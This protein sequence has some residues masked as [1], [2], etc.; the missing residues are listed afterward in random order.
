MNGIR[1]RMSGMSRLGFIG[2]I[3]VVAAIAVVAYF[4]IDRGPSEPQ[5]AGGPATVR[6]MSG[7]QYRNSISAIFGEDISTS[8]RFAPMRRTEGL[9]NLGSSTALVTPSTLMTFET[10]A[11]SV[12]AQVMDE[13]HRDILIPCSPYDPTK[14]DEAC[15][16]E[17][18]SAT[19]RLLY[20]QPIGEVELATY[21]DG[22]RVG[23]E[24]FSDFYKG[25]EN[26]LMGMLLAPQFVY[27]IEHSEPDPDN[28]G[29]LRLDAYSKAQRLS[30]LLW[31]APPDD[32][33]LLAAESGAIH[34]DKGLLEQVDRMLESPRLE[35]GT[36]AF[37]DDMLYMAKYD[38]MA[39]DPLLFPAAT[40]SVVTA[41][42]EQTMRMILDHL[43]DQNADYR[44]LFTT[45]RIFLTQ[46]LGPI[47]RM[48]VSVPGLHDWIAYELPED[49][50]RPGLL[51]QVGFLSVYAHP[52]RS[53]AT[54]RGKGLRE[55]FM[56][57]KVPDPP[58]NVDFSALTDPS[59][60]LTTT[61][62]RL[63]FH[64]KVPACAGCHK[65]TDPIG[66]SLENFDGAAQYRTAQNGEEIDASGT[67]SG[68][69]YNNAAGLAAAV[70]D[71]PAITSCLV[72]R[73]YK[74]AV[75]RPANAS[76]RHLYGYFDQKFADND[77][78]FVALLKTI[79]QSDAFFQ[80]SAA[81]DE[82]LVPEA[83]S[84]AAN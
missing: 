55:E 14:A 5:I 41:A 74:Y 81:P 36:R 40:L 79:T 1:Y 82:E 23:A 59:E 63:A 8:G 27:F 54:R 80:V 51:N 15:A 72:Q 13:A 4:N 66:L 44:D 7:L 17:F 19:G 60:E 31:N 62:K 77:Y 69:V 83:E 48:P 30:L 18:L 10:V 11:R 25:L 71:E 38:N 68:V 53:S 33:L 49:T 64:S 35:E 52:G 50:A 20:R 12:A 24:K 43:L 47:Y 37:F 46:A 2:V 9:E 42:K 22:A 67:F 26:A 61:R 73:L 16:R 56:C 65:I 78:R 58:P 75:S 32:A 6:L 70:R 29:E 84:V 45:R 57:Q 76:E 39:K 34:T 21:I 3:A 28:A